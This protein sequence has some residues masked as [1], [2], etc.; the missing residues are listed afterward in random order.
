MGVSPDHISSYGVKKN[1]WSRAGTP[2]T[3]PVGEIGG[4]DS[5]VF[6]DF[7]TPHNPAFGETCHPNCDC[8]RFI[9]IGNSVFMEYVKT[10]EGTFSKLPKKNVDFGGGL[11]RLTAATRNNADVFLIDVF[12]GARSLLEKYSN[13]NYE[14]ETVTHSF[15]IILDHL[16]AATFMIASGILPSNTEQGYILRRLIRRAIREADKLGVEG[17]ILSEIADTF[18]NIYVD[19]YPFVQ[20]N[21][22]QID[23]EL[24]KEEEQFR[25]TLS[26]GMRE[27]EKMGTDIDA[28]TLFTT[29]GFPVELTEEIAKESGVVL[30]MPA[31]KEKIKEHQALSR[32]GATQKFAG[33]LADH[34]EQTIKYHTAHHL[35][36]K[37][38]Q[39]VL[40]REVHQRGSNITSERLR[41]DFSYGQKM[42]PEQKEEVEKIVNQKIQESLPVVRTD[43]KREEAEKLGA[44][45]E[46]GTTYP[47]IVSVYSVGPLESAFSIEFCG[48]PHVKNT[49]ELGEGGKTFRILKEEASSAGVRRIKAVL[50]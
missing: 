5:E 11:E 23:K 22:A 17:V 12:D 16:R 15:R 38:L 26:Q 3:M 46:F 48:G 18:V 32:A 6:Y 24:R 7:G 41:I 42:T 21:K 14:D 35:L 10:A 45:H 25:K 36:L 27:L 20:A 43:M 40:G 19:A 9:E 47:E 2:N 44:E 30:D 37:A 34:A 13:K 50:E 1:W 4:P 29:Y 33:G 8:G 28:F 39:T 31:I 49:K